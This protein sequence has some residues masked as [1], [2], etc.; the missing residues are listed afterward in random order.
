MHACACVFMCTSM[1]TGIDFSHSLL[2][3]TDDKIQDKLN[4]CCLMCD[5]LANFITTD[6]QYLCAMIKS[7]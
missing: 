6:I 1:P 3:G 4:T 7:L 5:Y 2:S